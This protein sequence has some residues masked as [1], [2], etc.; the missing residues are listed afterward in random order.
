[1]TKIDSFDP[2]QKAP[3]RRPGPPPSSVGG[4]LRRSVVEAWRRLRTMRTALWLLGVLALE[5]V[6]ATI[7]PQWPNVPSTV[8]AWRDGTEGPGSVVAD[9]LDVVGA[10]DVYASPVFLATLLLLFTSLTA[11]LLPRIR[12]WW[13]ITR[14]SVPPLTRHLGRQEHVERM[15]SPLDVEEARAAARSVLADGRW[16]LR[17]ADADEVGVAQVAAE[18]G[19]VVREG[20]SLVFHLSFYVLLV[21]IVLGQLLTFEGFVSVVE[22]ESFTDTPIGYGIAQPGRW[23]GPEDHDGF[24]LS[25]DEFTVDWIRDPQSPN[26]GQPTTFEADVSVVEQDG[27]AT[28]ATIAGNRP[29]VVDGAKIHL[30]GW[31]YA[32]RIVVREAGEVVFDGF[33]TTV[34]DSEE[35]GFTGVVKAPA[36]EPDLGLELLLVPFAPDDER[37]VPQPTGAPWAEAPLLVF[38]PW[39]GDLGLDRPQRLDELDTTDMSAGF[40]D[41]VR[42]GEVAPLGFGREVEMVE[43]RRW[44]NLQVSRRPQVP[45]LLLG[46]ALLLGGLLPALYAYRRRLWVGFEPTGDGRTLVTVAG[47][48]FQR[49]ERFE[50]EFAELARALDDALDAGTAVARDEHDPPDPETTSTLPPD[51]AT[52]APA[53]TDGDRR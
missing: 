50:E 39:A 47:R 1:M 24:T 7:V 9:V 10:F 6:V 43:L 3:P 37:G 31:G 8:Q 34:F 45:G 49:S 32:P 22:G 16:R 4:L 26:A 5:S 25:V 53:P 36:A 21:S 29:L 13:R 40:Q 35:G 46:S 12:A 44:N 30:L 2:P 51:V 14:H 17:D 33:V 41:F 23:F 11:C 15:T 19:Q 42:P 18:K 52:A 48:A 27:T 38:T 20:G 28:T